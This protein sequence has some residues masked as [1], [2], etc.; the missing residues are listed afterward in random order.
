LYAHNTWKYFLKVTQ[1]EVEF[2]NNRKGEI[3]RLKLIQGAEYICKKI[4]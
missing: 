2:M 4:E 3:D 1:A